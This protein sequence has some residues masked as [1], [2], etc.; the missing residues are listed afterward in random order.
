KDEFGLDQRITLSIDNVTLDISYIIF[1]P[2]PIVVSGGDGGGGTKIIRGEDYT[3]VVIGLI[4]GIIG[5]VVVFGAYQA[6]FKHPPMVRKIRKLKKK[7][8]KGKTLKSLIVNPR[9]EIIRD[10]FKAKTRHVLDEEFLQSEIPGK[11]N[12]INKKGGK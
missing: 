6:H 7:I 10:N 9:D 5:L 11:I 2:N 4:A 8:K 3:P 1:A 12:K